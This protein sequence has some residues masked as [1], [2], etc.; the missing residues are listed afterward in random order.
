MAP[1]VK[2]TPQKL[3]QLLAT[4]RSWECDVR[5][6]LAILASVERRMDQDAQRPKS[7]SLSRLMHERSI[8]FDESHLVIE[9]LRHETWRRVGRRIGRARLLDEAKFE[10][11]S[12]RI[13][14]GLR[15]PPLNERSVAALLC[16][17]KPRKKQSISKQ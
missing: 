1:K 7:S 4:Y 13:H 6:A 17:S 3:R 12:T 14:N 2:Q 15:P 9:W 8:N 11:L 5:H 16:Q 10:R